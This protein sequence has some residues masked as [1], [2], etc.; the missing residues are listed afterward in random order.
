VTE[1]AETAPGPDSCCCE[2]ADVGVGPWMKVAESPECPVCTE[3][4]RALW[5]VRH[6]TPQARSEAQAYLDR[7]LGPRA[8]TPEDWQEWLTQHTGRLAD[9]GDGTTTPETNF[10]ARAKPGDTTGRYVKTGPLDWRQL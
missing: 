6:G 10:M 2:F 3:F 5:D 9:L 4:G 8:V 7:V 1:V